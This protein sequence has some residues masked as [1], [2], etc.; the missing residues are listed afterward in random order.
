[1]IL[2]HKIRLNPTEEQEV[3]FNRCVGT[4]RF[5][6]NYGLNRWMEAKAQGIQKFGVM[7]IKKELNFIKLEKFPW[8]YD[9]SKTVL[10]CA[11]I[12]LGKALSNRF[13]SKSGK[14]KGKKVGFPNFKSKKK[15]KYTFG[16]ANDRFCV[17]GHGFKMSLCP[18]VVN[19]AEA[20]R[21]SGKIMGANVSRVAGKWYVSIRVE[22]ENPIPIHFEKE[23]VGVDLGIKTL[24]VLSDGTQY[25]NQALLRKQQNKLKRLNRQLSR[26]KQGS[27]RWNKTKLKLS[28]FHAEIKDKRSDLIHKMTTKIAKTY[29]FVGVEDLNVAGMVGNRKLSLSISDAAF[30]EIVRQLEYKKKLYGGSIQKIGRFYPSSKTCGDCGAINKDLKLSDRSWVCSS[31]GTIHDR[32]ANAS[33]NIEKEALRLAYA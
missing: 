18:G 24:A 5:V 30:G 15:S 7:A 1:M 28:R 27:A 12:N 4:A 21:F 11:M 25:E 8:M 29:S 19:M 2:A 22:I 16:V 3:Y 17:D 9:V 6:F 20:L 14:R 26:R 33:E 32:D 13:E 31:C 23:S 10:E